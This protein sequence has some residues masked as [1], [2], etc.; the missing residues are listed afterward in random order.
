MSCQFFVLFLVGSLLPGFSLTFS[1]PSCCVFGCLRCAC[2]LQVQCSSNLSTPDLETELFVFILQHCA[3]YVQDDMGPDPAAAAAAAYAVEGD[4]MASSA[5][6]AA[7]GKR[8]GRRGGGGS[9]SER[10]TA[11][12]RFGA[13]DILPPLVKLGSAL[14]VGALGSR[15][16]ERL[17]AQLVRQHLAYQAA[18]RT[19]TGAATKVAGGALSSWQRQAALSAAQKGLTAATAR[20]SALR[21]VMSFVGP[22]MWVWLVVD[23]AFAAVGTDYTRVIRAVFLMAQVRLVRTNGFVNPLPKVEETLPQQ[24]QQTGG[25]GSAQSGHR[26]VDVAES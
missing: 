25:R 3:E 11:P 13:P 10:L 4:G 22:A 20:Y 14:A 24:Q 7:S 21:G 18:L 26:T 6:A 1:A 9:W 23:L 12:F 8:D 5:A 19:A 15:A 16:A 2:R 17:G